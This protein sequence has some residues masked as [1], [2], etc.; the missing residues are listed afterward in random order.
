M[1]R[2]VC[3]YN[4]RAKITRDVCVV[5]HPHLAAKVLRPLQHATRARYARGAEGVKV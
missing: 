4:F 2:M 3:M 5:C 1:Q